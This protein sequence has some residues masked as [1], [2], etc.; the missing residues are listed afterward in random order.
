MASTP[1]PPHI[2]DLGQRKFSFYPPIVNIEHNHWTYLRGNWSE[3]LV[4][5]TKSELE[6][7]IPRSYLG[8]VSKVEEPV[9]ILGLKREL[10][11]KS[12]SIWPHTR[13]VLPMPAAPTVA[14]G[15][16]APEEASSQ[17]KSAIQETLSALKSSSSGTESGLGKM[18][19]MALLIGILITV[20]AI[21]V[22]RLRTT[23]GTVEYK[24]VL[25]AE[26]DFTAQSD[27]FDVVRKLG[28]PEKDR[29]RSEVGERQYRALDYSK[30][31]VVI[32]LMGADRETAHYIGAKNGE[33]ATIHS[34]ELPGGRSTEAILRALKRF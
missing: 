18:I 11:Y 6:I 13:R 21:T 5:N 12:G 20:A 14:K 15:G 7:W 34:V 24:P 27:Y 26:L 8:E 22:L 16:P 2:D 9:M 10:E 28:K 17:K 19:G 30:G 32:I 3:I 33:W 23:G 31:N 25:Q 1:V 4:K 29:W